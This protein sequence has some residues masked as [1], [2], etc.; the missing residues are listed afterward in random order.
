MQA[1]L[2]HVLELAHIAG[3]A[4]RLKLR[5]RVGGEARETRAAEL[6]RHAAGEMLGEQ[7]DVLDALAQRRNGDDVESEAVE[8][9]AAEAA[10][11]G[12]RR[13]VDI[14]GGDDADID[15]AAPRCRRRARSC[16]TR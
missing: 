14:G 13:Q 1:A 15:D 11:R 2:D 8:E 9:I 7:R 10:G 3:P 5:Q 4:M 6:A 16:R 12:Q